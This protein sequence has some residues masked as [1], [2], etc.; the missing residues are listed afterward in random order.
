MSENGNQRGFFPASFAQQRLWFLDRL[1]PGSPWYNI[2]AAV[3]LSFPLDVAVLK[4][5]V[6]EIVRRHESLRTTF[7]VEDGRPV[8]IIAP[9]LELSL[10]LT[11]LRHL[12][13]DKQNAK[14]MRLATEEARRP[15]DLAQGPL[16]R[17][18][19]LQM[20]HN[21]YVFLL[22]IHHIVADGWSMGIF[23]QELTALYLAFAKG[24]PSPLP[25][26][27][28]QYAD[29]A[30][31]QRDWLQGKVLQQQLDYWREQLMDLPVLQLPNDRF[32]PT[33]Q[34]YRGARYHL[35]L[36]GSLT[37]SL[38]ALGQQEGATLFM[39][40]LA[41]FQALLVRYTGQEDIV[42]GSPIANRNRAEIEPLIGFFVNTLVLRTDCGSDPTF[43]E[44]LGRVRE[45]ALG[46]YAH[47]D[48]PFEMLVE[49]LQPQR[50][51][52]RN[53]LFQVIFQLLNTPGFT[54]QAFAG[55]TSQR[56]ALAVQS[57]TSKFDL[58]FDLWESPAGLIGNFEYNTDL[59]DEATIARMARH[60]QTL[61]EGIVADPDQ[62]LSRLPLL[63]EPERRQILVGWNATQTDYPRDACIHERF[64]AQAEHTP[65]AVAVIFEDGQRTYGELN[66]Q[67]N[68]LAH[69]LRNLGVGPG[70]LVGVCLERSVEMVT[71]LLGILKAGG[72]YVPLDPSYPTARLA[73]IQEDT[74][75]PV[76]LTQK[77]LLAAL[78][79]PRAQVLCL[80]RERERIAGQSTANPQGG[81]TAG[82]LAYV[83][84]TSGSTGEP[85][86]VCVPHR[87]VIRLVEKTNYIRLDASDRMA[88]VSNMSFDAATF[89]IWGSLLH[90]ARLIGVM[91]DVALSPQALADQ[92]RRQGITVL[93]L[94]T[95][96]FNQMIREAPG[97]FSSVRHLL[98]GGEAVDP[99]WI[100]QAL[101]RDPPERLLNAYGPTETTTFATWH[102]V[103]E[104]PEGATTVPIGRP[105]S[106]TQL[107][108]LDRRRQP[109]PIGVPGELYIG[110]DGL[111]T[112]YL[113]RP[114][115]TA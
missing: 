64:E 83:M 48:L 109:V 42:V 91:K 101:R 9:D 112:G 55:P 106:N 95:A 8:Q 12:P 68:Q 108:V 115:L 17:T 70:S 2:P 46:A 103:Q 14:A 13:H 99:R 77:S 80:D 1:V 110:G 105:I 82:D 31:W 32:R 93:F 51:L 10:P 94:T 35:T 36:P 60:Y 27:P 54:Q 78:P 57:G 11:D 7:A 37:A 6:N 67:A 86:G 69:H 61:L 39:T 29:F 75:A 88:Q 45:V 5:C 43:R 53:P 97:A 21:D 25:E 111:A 16:V 50:D 38:K 34:G 85:K 65:D 72:A 19:L 114:E 92:I 63:T 58:E 59:F 90:G 73:F 4:R 26:L 30:V 79:A 107:Y 40:L 56:A 47:Q 23:F 89:E 66:A 22:T 98:V 96:L 74:R 81:A 28:I 33:E 102:L 62:P 3:P 100:R 24:H 84:Y 20:G 18:Q 52:G 113:R 49:K 44:L 71:A 87:A 41:A 15:F 104:V 76:L